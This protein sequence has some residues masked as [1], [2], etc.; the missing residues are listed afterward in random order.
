MDL[1]LTE[2]KKLAHMMNIAQIAYEEIKTGTLK[3]NLEKLT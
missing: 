2:N 3:Q 1:S